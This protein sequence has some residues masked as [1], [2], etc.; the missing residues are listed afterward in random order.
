M[1]KPFRPM[2]PPRVGY[3]EVE[4]DGVRQHK[5]IEPEKSPT[6]DERLEAAEL[7]LLALLDGGIENV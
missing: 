1:N 2:L 4:I 7:A 5:K 3:I 6:L